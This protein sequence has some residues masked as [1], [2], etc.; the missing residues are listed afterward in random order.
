MVADAG[1]WSKIVLPFGKFV[2]TNRGFV[3]GPQEL[4][5]RQVFA[6]A[7]MMAE[8]KDGPFRISIRSIAAVAMDLVE[9]HSGGRWL[10]VSRD[11]RSEW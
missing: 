5:A 8:R 4:D 2:A 3:E 1:K 7:I 11:K 6:V 10:G 9:S